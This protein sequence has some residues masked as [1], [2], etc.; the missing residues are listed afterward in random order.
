MRYEES[1]RSLMSNMKAARIAPATAKA[2][3]VRWCGMLA[4]GRG[5]LR[6]IHTHRAACVQPSSS[7]PDR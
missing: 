7:L 2:C 4:N 6:N 5:R 1:W 3:K